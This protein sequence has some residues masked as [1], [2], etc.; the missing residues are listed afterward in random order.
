MSHRVAATSLD[1]AAARMGDVLRDIAVL[2]ARKHRGSTKADK[3]VCPEKR[4]LAVLFT[5]TKRA[6]SSLFFQRRFN[7]GPGDSA[8]STVCD[9][10][11]SAGVSLSICASL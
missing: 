4:F 10:E 9:P 2:G 8:K 11:K 3:G 1:A 7:R 6:K 5:R